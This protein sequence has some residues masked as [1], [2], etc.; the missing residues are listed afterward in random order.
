MG[1]IL[2]ALKIRIYP[3][4][5]QQIQI[6]KTI[7]SCRFIYNS[8]LAE[9]ISTYEKLKDDKRKLYTHKYKTEKEFKQEFEWLK[10]VDSIALQ[11]ARMDLS[12]AYQNF[13]KSLSGKRKGSSGFPKF[14][15]KGRKDSY[16]TTITNDNIKI[17][18]ESQKVKLPKIGWVTFKDLRKNIKGEIKQATV[19]R[20]CTGKY[21]VSI[22]FEQELKLDGVEINSNLK[23]K[24]LDMSLASFY[25]DDE[26]NSPVYERIYRNNEPRL[27]WLQRQTSKKVKGSNNRRKAQLRVNLLYEQITNRRKDFS[28]KLSTKLVKENDVIIVENLNLKAMAQCLKL[29]K[30]VNDL[31]YGAFLAQ[32][33]YK[34]LWNNKILIEADKWFASS[35]TCSKCGFVH[36]NLQLQDRI[37]NC[38]SCGFEV[39]RDQNAGI[40]LKNYGLKEIGLGESKFKPVE[41]G[42]HKVPSMKQEN[43]VAMPE[44]QRSLAVDSFTT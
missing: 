34:T 3:T 30:S 21:F 7:G 38:P 40:N 5:E 28:Q 31:G 1:N 29:G 18:F 20:T 19:S 16:R 15:K 24:G 43:L 27:A 44:G 12:S 4:S 41:T 26:G 37:F 2:K 6:N 8:M 14:H 13:F 42:M 32:L 35:K 33:K 9:K 36:K 39:D 23:T 11:Q 22:L 17:D 10:E 25:V